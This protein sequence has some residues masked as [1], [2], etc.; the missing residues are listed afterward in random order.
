ME[1]MDEILE[2]LHYHPS[3]KRVE[4]E[5]GLA[6]DVSSATVKRVLARGL[7]DGLIRIRNWQGYDVFHYAACSSA[8]NGRS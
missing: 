2:F 5:K 6:I 3:S 8:E 1:L 7:A 4:V